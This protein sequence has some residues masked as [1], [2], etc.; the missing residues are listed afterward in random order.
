MRGNPCFR[1]HLESPTP[2]SSRISP[3]SAPAFG[4]TPTRSRMLTCLMC[5]DDLCCCAGHPEC[6][7]RVAQLFQK[8][9]DKKLLER[10][11]TLP[12]RKVR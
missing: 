2:N 10:C 1:T 5:H 4:C 12:P 3:A 6:P 11:W 8:L 9:V 7:E